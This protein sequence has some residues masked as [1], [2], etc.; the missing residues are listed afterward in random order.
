MRLLLQV[1]CISFHCLMININLLNRHFVLRQRTCFVRTDDR[2]TSEALHCFQ[3][4]DNGMFFGHFLGS[5][6]LYDGDN[7]TQSL[8]N[9]SHRQSHCKHQCI[10][11]RHP[12]VQT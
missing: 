7:G 4:F 3:I 1:Q 11:H 12:S 6:G 5:H 2:Y 8:R 10:Q 9:G